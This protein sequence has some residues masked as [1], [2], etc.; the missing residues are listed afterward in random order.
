MRRS[1]TTGISELIAAILK[2]NG[3]EDK[4]YENRVLNAWEDLLG[5]NIAHATKNL[6]IRDRV[7]F[8]IINSSIIRHEVT[9]LRDDLVKRLNEKAGKLVIDT[10][11]IR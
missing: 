8:V 2:Q 9:M 6:Y 1:K 10:I 4:L 5:R 11:V 3:I 7:L